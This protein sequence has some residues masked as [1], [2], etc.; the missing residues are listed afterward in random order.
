MKAVII[1]PRISF[2]AAQ[3]EWFGF[4]DNVQKICL[5]EITLIVSEAMQKKFH[6]SYIWHPFK[7]KKRELIFPPKYSIFQGNDN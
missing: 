5:L 1:R 6:L 4:L 3:L 2:F 7:L